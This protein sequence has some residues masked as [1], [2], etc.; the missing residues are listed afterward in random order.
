MEDAEDNGIK[1][2]QEAIEY[3]QG[4]FYDILYFVLGYINCN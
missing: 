3:R 4:V 2:E 1:T